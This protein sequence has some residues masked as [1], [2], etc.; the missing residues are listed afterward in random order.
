ME[1]YL[2]VFLFQYLQILNAIIC[3]ILCVLIITLINPWIRYWASG[4]MRPTSLIFL[5]IYIC[6]FEN[7]QVFIL[8]KR[9][10]VKIAINNVIYHFDQGS[11]LPWRLL[12]YMKLQLWR[13]IILWKYYDKYIENI[14]YYV[15]C[16][17]IDKSI[18]VI[19]ICI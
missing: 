10:D 14:L 13:R 17:K 18:D 12:E 19:H 16:I 3:G 1:R 11:H 5:S 8:L 9:D 2:P 7:K 6:R 4:E 15:G